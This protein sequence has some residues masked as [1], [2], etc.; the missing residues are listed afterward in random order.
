[1]LSASAVV[2]GSTDLPLANERSLQAG[3]R[4]YQS[5]TCTKEEAGDCAH[6]FKDH[7]Y[8]TACTEKEAGGVS[9]YC[10]AEYPKTATGI[11]ADQKVLGNYLNTK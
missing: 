5:A 3:P 4:Q 7:R 2:L 11:C 1:M 6:G 9:D 10:S 8:P